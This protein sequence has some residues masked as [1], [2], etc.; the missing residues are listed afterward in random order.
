MSA[1]DH[2]DEVPAVVGD[3]NGP[4][5]GEGGNGPGL[6][7]GGNGLELGGGGNGALGMEDDIGDR[8]PPPC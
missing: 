7:E 8:P 5:L 6:G 3:G 2:V 4:G 1:P